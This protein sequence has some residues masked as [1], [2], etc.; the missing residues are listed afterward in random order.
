MGLNLVQAW[1]QARQQLEAAGIAGPVIDARLL[2]EAAAEATRVDI[3]TDPYRAL[4]AEQEARL[5]DYLARRAGR[6]PVSHILGRKGFWKL[7]LQVTPDVL[8]PRPDTETV[9]EYVLRDFPEDAAWTVLDLGVG[10]GAILL[11]IL[12]ERPA[13][14]GVGIDVSEAALEVARENAALLGLADRAQL[15]HGDWARGVDDASFDLVV[16]N[17]PYIASHVIAELE[18]EV[19]D[20]EPRLALEGG[21]DGLDAYRI[22]AP[23]ILRVLKPGGRFAVEIGYDQ[24]QAVEALFRAAGAGAVQTLRDLGDRD[25]VVS[26]VKKPLETKA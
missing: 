2:V 12:A 22:L 13:A 6:E 20:H 7:M 11:S 9:V 1:K 16:S 10:S 19:R 5:D 26:G 25:R 8:T 24:K 23:E 17:P 21:A 18:P 4:T 3:V 14:T 15:S